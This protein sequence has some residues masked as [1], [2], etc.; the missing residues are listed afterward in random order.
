[1]A[2]RSLVPPKGNQ[3]ALKHGAYTKDAFKRHAQVR[4]LMRE[5]QKLIDS[6]RK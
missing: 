4:N 1:M 6:I 5:A 3:N 2:L